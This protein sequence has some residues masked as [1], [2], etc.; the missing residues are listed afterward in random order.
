M[1]QQGAAASQGFQLGKVRFCQ[2]KITQQ[3]IIEAIAVLQLQISL[4][5]RYRPVPLQRRQALEYGA[6]QLTVSGK[7]GS[8]PHA[9]GFQP[10]IPCFKESDVQAGVPAWVVVVPGFQ[11]TVK[12]MLLQSI[13][14]VVVQGAGIEHDAKIMGDF[15]NLLRFHAVVDA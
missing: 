9:V 8:A 3:D 15:G 11:F 7:E 10:V 4:E 1:Q 14:E 6:T 2:V 5:G 12:T 13:Q